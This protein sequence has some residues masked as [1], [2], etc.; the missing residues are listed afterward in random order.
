MANVPAKKIEKIINKEGITI[1]GYHVIESIELSYQEEAERHGMTDG[2]TEEFDFSCDYSINEGML[3]FYG[4]ICRDFRS[5]SPTQELPYYYPYVE[6][7]TIKKGDVAEKVV[8]IE[9]YWQ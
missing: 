1:D 2:I 4:R 7:C 3:T 6:S 9:V 8:G 5:V